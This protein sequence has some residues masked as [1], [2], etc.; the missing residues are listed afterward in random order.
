MVPCRIDLQNLTQALWSSNLNNKTRI[1]F[2]RVKTHFNNDNNLNF[3][4]NTTPY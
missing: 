1:M 4:T 3:L 2:N